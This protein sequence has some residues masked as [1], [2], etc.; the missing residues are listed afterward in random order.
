MGMRMSQV[1]RPRGSLRLGQTL[2]GHADFCCGP[3]AQTYFHFGGSGTH[4]HARRGLRRARATEC[5]CN[6]A[7]LQYCNIAKILE[8]TYQATVFRNSP[9]ARLTALF[10]I[11]MMGYAEQSYNMGTS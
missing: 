6:I 1:C 11:Q 5:Y 7:I 10:A 8:Y 3:S 9:Q 2:T 4:G